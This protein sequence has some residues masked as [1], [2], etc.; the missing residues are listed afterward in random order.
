MGSRVFSGTCSE[1]S[2]Q[3]A[4]RHHVCGLT[5][6]IGGPHLLAQLGNGSGSPRAV[7]SHVGCCE[8]LILAGRQARASAMSRRSSPNS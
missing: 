8:P 5:W 2:H 7:R 6:R 3:A 1:W 4:V